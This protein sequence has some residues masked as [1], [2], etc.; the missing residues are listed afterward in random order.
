MQNIDENR[1]SPRYVD[2]NTSN[3]LVGT[4]ATCGYD[5]LISYPTFGRIVVDT[6]HRRTARQST[7]K[8]TQANPAVHSY[9]EVIKVRI[10]FL[11]SSPLR[12]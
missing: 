9:R 4:S 3:T 11:K 2:G 12:S 10:P 5:S 7:S 8:F 6:K 1:C